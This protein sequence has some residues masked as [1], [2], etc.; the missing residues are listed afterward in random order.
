MKQVHIRDLMAQPESFANQMIQVS[1]WVRTLRSSKAFGFIELNDGTHFK[2]MQIVF[3]ADKIDNFEE[4]SKFTIAT[5]L[6]VEGGEFVLTPDSKQ[7]FELKATK[8]VLE[9]ASDSDYPL[10]KNVI[11]LSI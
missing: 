3:E 2:N 4:V 9:A 5:A 11:L 10:Q 1:G 7:P 8:V 6:T